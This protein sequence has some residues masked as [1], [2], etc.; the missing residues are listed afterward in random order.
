MYISI[1]GSRSGDALR[2]GLSVSS[3]DTDAKVFME[4]RLL[5]EKFNHMQ[6]KL[7]SISD[8]RNAGKSFGATESFGLQNRTK[9]GRESQF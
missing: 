5:F 1:W 7:H 3:M 9:K 8:T 4:R 2:M 6:A